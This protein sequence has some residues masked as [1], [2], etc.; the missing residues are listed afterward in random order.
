MHISKRC[1]TFNESKN[2]SIYSNIQK[3]QSLKMIPVKWNETTVCARVPL[4][5]SLCESNDGLTFTAPAESIKKS[6]QGM[7]AR[8]QNQ[9]MSEERSLG[10]VG[11]LL[12]RGRMLSIIS[13]IAEHINVCSICYTLQEHLGPPECSWLL[14]IS[15]KCIQSKTPLWQ[16]NF[17][18]KEQT[19]FTV[20]AQGTLT[21]ALLYANFT[22]IFTC[23]D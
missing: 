11:N 18:A 20:H 1:F 19:T 3:H 10:F 14:I 2:K 16:H 13:L 9:I 4:K 17:H 8:V 7:L 6:N 23:T 12:N 22:K 21:T 15:V 5:V